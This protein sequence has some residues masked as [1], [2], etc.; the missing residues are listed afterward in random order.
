MLEQLRDRR[1]T[2]SIQDLHVV[3]KYGVRAATISNWKKD[4]DTQWSIWHEQCEVV[5][6]LIV[7]VS[8]FVFVVTVELFS[9]HVI[10]SGWTVV[11]RN[12]AV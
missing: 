4:A 10:L 5:E 11:E 12:R 6:T 1:K 8:R 7:C 9:L 2:T 3:L